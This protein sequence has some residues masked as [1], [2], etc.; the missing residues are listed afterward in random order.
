MAE[1]AAIN[2]AEV[3][4]EVKHD[5]SRTRSL[6]IIFTC[7]SLVNLII[8]LD[9]GAVPAA[10]LHIEKTFVLSAGEIGLLG[11]LV[12]QGIAIGSLLVGPVTHRMSPKTATQITLVLNTAATFAFGASQNTAMFL[13]FRILIGFLQAIPAVYFPVWVDEFAPASSATVWMAIVQAG[14]PLGIMFGYVFSGVLTAGIDED[15]RCLPTDWSC[16]W[17]YA[18]FLQY[19]ATP[20]A[21]PQPN[22]G[23]SP[24]SSTQRRGGG[25]GGGGRGP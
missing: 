15:V 19:A 1:A 24:N 2:Q 7:M 10:L 3:K 14:A 23:V 16:K 6:K 5:K 13:V 12:Y 18:F 17:R 8:N 25:N 21:P 9:G 20:L 11:M 22:V 4:V